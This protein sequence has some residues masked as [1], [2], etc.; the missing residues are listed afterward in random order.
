MVTL[1]R[2]NEWKSELGIIFALCCSYLDL[3]HI[4]TAQRV[5][6]YEI[7]AY[8]TVRAMAEKLGERQAVTLLSKTLQEEK[9][10]DEK[11][12]EL[13]EKMKLVGSDSKS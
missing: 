13:A 5:E 3:F 9:D 8:R 7:A 1:W 10:T 4:G 2:K 12:T 6:H 11:L